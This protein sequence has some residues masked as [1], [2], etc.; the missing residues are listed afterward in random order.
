MKG[1]QLRH[2]RENRGL[3]RE[4]LAKE[5]GDCSASG[6]VKWETGVSPVPTWV[7][8]KMLRSVKLELPLE[9]LELLLDYA[10]REGISFTHLL[11]DAIRLL[12]KSPKTGGNVHT[13]PGQETS[14]WLDDEQTPRGA[15]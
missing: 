10:K 6:I 9:E 14:P 4:Q 7:E 13:F 15:G 11:G 12:L 2:L 8:E 5:L 1:D 3:T